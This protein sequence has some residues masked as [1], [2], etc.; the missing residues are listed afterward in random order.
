[1]KIQTCGNGILLPVFLAGF[2]L[3]SAACTREPYNENRSA[4]FNTTDFTFAPVTADAAVWSIRGVSTA[5]GRMGLAIGLGEDQVRIVENSSGTWTDLTTLSGNG[6]MTTLVDIAPG[7]SGTWWILASHETEG[8]R[9]Y[10]IGGASDSTLTIPPYSDTVWD[11]AGSALG[12][13]AAGR[14]VAVLKARGA[15]LFRVALADTGWS[16]SQINNSTLNSYAYDYDVDDTD[17]GHLLFRN[18]LSGK[19]NYQK[20]GPDST[21]NRSFPPDIYTV[22]DLHLFATPDGRV[23][24]IGGLYPVNRI[25]YWQEEQ[26]L[27]VAESIPIDEPF[28]SHAA[29]GVAPDDRPWVVGGSYQGSGRFNLYLVTRSPED[30]GINWTATPIVE[31]AAWQ[32]LRNRMMVF[33]IAVDALGSPHIILVTGESGSAE[34]V[35]Q[36]AVPK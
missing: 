9:L 28:L 27:D 15:T 29:A 25:V 33:T 7:P 6:L 26:G 35:I 22:E 18:A 20:A 4:R 17:T 12:S 10:R 32:S 23:R 16:V 21:V 14:P 36:E 31:G 2:I 3:A 5:D 8:M 19:M 1:M 24:L 13:D 30:L 34:S 11:T